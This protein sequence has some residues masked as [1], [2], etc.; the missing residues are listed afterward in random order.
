MAIA[1]PC[2]CRDGDGFRMRNPSYG[3]TEPLA[4]WEDADRIAEPVPEY[5]TRPVIE[6]IVMHV[7]SMNSSRSA[8]GR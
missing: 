7:G 3:L 4:A 8:T 1:R 2:L 5:V 6:Q